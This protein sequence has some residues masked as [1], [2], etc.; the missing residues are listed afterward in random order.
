MSIKT[1]MLLIDPDELLAGQT[2]SWLSSFSRMN[3]TEP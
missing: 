2:N 3:I 1:T